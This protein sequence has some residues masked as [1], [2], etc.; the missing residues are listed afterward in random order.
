VRSTTSLTIGAC[1]LAVLVAAE[2]TLARRD[3]SPPSAI[4]RLVP[5]GTTAGRTA[6]AFSLES[7]GSSLLYLRSKGLWRCAQAFGAV[8]ETDRVEA[9]LSAVLDTRGTLVCADAE[10]AARSGFD[11]P[12]ALS[13]GLHG[14][15]VLSDDGRD[16]IARVV[17]APSRP[18]AT[19]ARLEGSGRVLAV[20]RDA[21]AF[22]DTNGRPAPLV[23][24]RLLAGCLAPGFAGFQRIFVDRGDDGFELSSEE[25]AVPG[26]ERRWQLVEGDARRETILWRIGGYVSLWVRARWDR[27]E[28][29]RQAAA[30]GLDPPLARVTLAPNVGP[31]VE[32]F[33]SAADA[34]NRVHVWNRATNVVAAV[35][36][37]LLPLIVPQPEDF[38]RSEGANPWEAWLVPR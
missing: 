36:A 15:Q 35:G 31:T 16:L 25:P 2:R 10:C 13:L 3:A 5:P 14:P 18:G 1:L 19:F 23:D 26:Q 28:D 12:A 22:L 37:E 34:A 33:V 20:D 9:L 11:D 32:V 6:A 30:L 24:T 4:E 27:I 7:G 8:C 17:Y 21:R 38:T 29:P